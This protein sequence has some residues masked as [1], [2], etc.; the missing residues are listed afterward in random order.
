MGMVHIGAHIDLWSRIKSQIGKLGH[1]RWV[2]A[3]LK[4]ENAA[5]A[6]VSYEDWSGNKQADLKAKE[7]SEKH[8][9][10]PSQKEK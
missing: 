6:G 1:I 4:E 3:H 5:A 10:N 2:K 8:G 7:G 9:Y